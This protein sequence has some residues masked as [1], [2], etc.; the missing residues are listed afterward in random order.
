MMVIMMMMLVSASLLFGVFQS[1]PATLMETW[2]EFQICE[3]GCQYS[4]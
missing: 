2:R 3:E 1:D 4:R